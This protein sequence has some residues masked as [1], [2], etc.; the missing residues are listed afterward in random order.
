MPESDGKQVSA[1]HAFIYTE[2][3]GNNSML[4]NDTL[5][6]L[7]LGV[8]TIVLLIALERAHARNRELMNRLASN[9]D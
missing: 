7:F 4:F 3:Q 1:G 6:V 9:D 8:L 2:G 5:G